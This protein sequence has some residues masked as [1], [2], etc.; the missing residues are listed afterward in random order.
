M[1]TKDTLSSC[2]NSEEQQMQQIQDK[3]KKSCMVS[4][5]QLYSHLKLLSNNDLK[6]TGTESGFKRAY[7]TL[8]GQN[9]ET[10]I[11]T[12]FLHMD[13]LEKKLDN[14]EFQEIRSMAS[15]KILEFRDTLMQHMESVKKLIDERALHKRDYDTRD[16]RS[17]LG[18]DARADDADIRTIYDE[19]PMAEV[20]TTAKINV[21]ATGQQHT[22]RLEFNNEGEV[23]QNAEQYHDTCP[24]PAKL[25]DNQTTEHSNQSLESKNIWKPILQPHRNQSV[26]RQPTAFKS[27]RPRISKPQF[28]SQVDVNND[29]SKP[30]TTHY[31]PKERES[32]VAKPH[33][34][35]SPS[36]S[37][38]SSND[39]VHNH[40]LDEAKKK[41]QESGRNSRPSVMPSAKSQSTTNGSK[42]KPRSNT[43]TSRNWP[44]S[45]NSEF[46][47][48]RYS[49]LATK[50]DSE[51]TNGSNDDI[52][53]QYECEQT[54]NVSAG[55]LNLS[56]GTSFSPKKEGL[57]VYNEPSS[58]KLVPKLV[59]SAD[60]IAT[61]RK[62]LEFLFHHYITLL[63]LYGVGILFQLKSDSLP[64]AHAQTTKTYYKHQDSSIKKAQHCV[65]TRQYLSMGDFWNGYLRKGR[66]TKPKRQNR[67]QNGKAWSSLSWPKL[68]QWGGTVT[69]L[70]DGKKII[71]TKSSVRRDLQLAD[72]EDEAVYKELGDSLVRDATTASSLEAEQ[73]SGGGP[74]CQEIMRDT[75]AQTRFESVSKHSN[76]SLL[77]RGNTLQSDKDRLKLDEL[78][79]L[80]T[81][82]QN[83]VLDLEKTKTT[84]HNE[85][86][87]LK[88]RVKKLE[89]KDRSRTHRLNILYKVG[90]TA[91]V[92]S[93]N[94][95]ESL[96]EDASKHGRI[97]A[98]DADEEITMVSVHDVNVF[99]GEEVFATTVDD[100]TLAQEKGK[101]ILIE[102]V[103]L[104]NKKDL[105]R[106][107]DE[108]ALNLQAEFDEEERLAR[109]KAE[110]EKEANIALIETWDDIQAKIDV[111][112]QLAKRM[113]AQEQE[114]LSIE[115]KATLF[116]QL[117]E[118][119]RK[120]FAAKRVE[121]KRNKPPTTAQQ[122]KIMC[123]YLKNMERYKLKDLKLKEFR[124]ELVKGKEKRAGTKLIQEIIKK[125][126]V[127]DDKET[128]EPK[129]LMKIIPAKDEVAID[130]I[131]LTVKS[132]TIVDW[133]I[134]K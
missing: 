62:D 101:G 16:T 98:I 87:S 27:K 127:K 108:T 14:K 74:W 41:T 114:E 19:E 123:T 34:M 31:L 47:L 67:T 86:A 68:H 70:V 69:S 3:A 100:I 76:D 97:D 66:K 36:S 121:E 116:Q 6:G 57:R 28:A 111:D 48:E 54:L 21:F 89:K 9:V 124:T 93:S 59:P 119:R 91:R 24:F 60:K 33:H 107:D 13:Q 32:V 103:K 65:R 46:L 10:F 7:A 22:K 11:G 105:I 2:S 95:E 51:P 40:Y 94:N 29:L 75:I 128:T 129:Q 49:P 44:T 77:V 131:P 17:R 82:L 18:N 99:A 52:T 133:K 117:L 26:V 23:D 90:L 130:A 1:E 80:C 63:R 12:M 134:Y 120:H 109:E 39:M 126:K 5:Q 45:K 102:L 30:I 118:K 55:T 56:A 43:Q 132:P 125:Q 53:N 113:Q 83:Q 112:H 73:D 104:M 122:R 37:R 78:M 4:F 35:I 79:A 115:E 42:P 15:F 25:T 71:I 88:R 110:K 50:V 92:E 64:H 106:L 81:T 20:Q 96:G 38:Y 85:I 8:F 58:S 61:S 84:Q 72:E